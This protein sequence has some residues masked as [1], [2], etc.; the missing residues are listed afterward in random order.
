MLPITSIVVARLEEIDAFNADAVYQA[1]FL[2][3]PP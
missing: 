2:R 3:N 1:V